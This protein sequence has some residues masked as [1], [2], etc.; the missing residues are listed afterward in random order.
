VTIHPQEDLLLDLRRIKKTPEGRASLR[1]RVAI[2]HH[3]ARVQAVQ[4]PRA[5]YKGARK[6]TLDRRRCAAVANLQRLA[7]AA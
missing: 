6:N 5:R 1:E 4:G 3:L 2:E 7:T